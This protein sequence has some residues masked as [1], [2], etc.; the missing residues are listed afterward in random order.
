MVSP[1]YTV[2]RVNKL[3]TLYSS[4]TVL[5]RRLRMLEPSQLWNKL[6][7]DIINITSTEEFERALHNKL[8]IC[9]KNTHALTIF[10][11]III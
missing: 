9:K 1:I 5:R 6:S 8:N 7:N 10:V 3:K 4:G 11:Y 2:G